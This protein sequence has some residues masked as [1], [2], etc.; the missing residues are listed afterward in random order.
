MRGSFLGGMDFDTQNFSMCFSRFKYRQFTDIWLLK[1][2]DVTMIFYR[3]KRLIIDNYQQAI[4]C[5]MRR[6]PAN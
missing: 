2:T 4:K 6:I 1:E 5:Y 3:H